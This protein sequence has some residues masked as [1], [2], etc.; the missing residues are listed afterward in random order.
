MKQ[1]KNYKNKKEDF[2]SITLVTIIQ[3]IREN[4]V[5]N[6]NMT[7]AELLI[8]LNKTILKLLPDKSIH[9]YIFLYCGEKL[10]YTSQ[11]LNALKISNGSVIMAMPLYEV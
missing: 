5:V 11:N 9:E 8:F 7:G 2:I 6:K 1:N 4:L 10:R 3:D